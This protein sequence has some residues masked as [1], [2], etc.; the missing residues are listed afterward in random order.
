MMKI[1]KRVKR[2]AKEL[3][4]WCMVDSR[5][6]ESRVRLVAQ[7]V[8]AGG[9]RNRLAV[10]AHFRRLVKLEL[11]RQTATIESATPLPLEL[12]AAIEAGLRQRYGPQLTTS[13]ATRPS[14][15]GGIR[16]QVG[17]DVYDG[18]VRGRLVALENRF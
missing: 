1:T 4:H 17:S 16:I 5:L 3:I 14:L 9:D 7:R 2:E 10:L 18:S 13:V 15:I 8:A 6:E 12:Q 11:G